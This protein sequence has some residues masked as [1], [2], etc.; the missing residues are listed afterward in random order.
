MSSGSIRKFSAL[1]LAAGLLVAG[2]ALAG[3]EPVRTIALTV[4]TKGY[5][6][7]PI[8]VAKDK[9]VKLVITRKTDRTCAR[10]IVIPGYG[11]KEK[12]PLDKAVEITFTPT[13]SGNLKYGCGMR[14][15]V[16]GVLVVE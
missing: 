12:L 14:Q 1:A 4:T 6:P 7:T 3:E 2:A 16:S 10:E 13:K 15:M 11:I 9:P 5:E 8:K